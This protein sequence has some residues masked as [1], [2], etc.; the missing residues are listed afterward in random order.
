MRHALR[1]VIAII[2]LIKVLPGAAQETS[3]PTA[4]AIAF[5]DVDI[6]RPAHDRIDRHQTVVLRGQKISAIGPGASL[7]PPPGVR[8]ID[9]RVSYLLA[10]LAE[11][12]AH[13][14]HQ[15]A[16]D[17]YLQDVLFLWAPNGITTIRGM[18]G[19]PSHL[20]LREGRERQ[21]FLG[22]RLLTAGPPFIGKKIK[23]AEGTSR[24]VIG[25]HEAGYGFIKV[26]MGSTVARRMRQPPGPAQTVTCRLPGM[27][28][29]RRICRAPWSSARRQSII[30][31]LTGRRWSATT[32][33]SLISIMDCLVV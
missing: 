27:S 22:P 17:E 19:E 28:R 13:V 8:E 11:M 25:Q 20:E 24:L 23:T 1:I 16:T 6:V 10:G 12:H 21:E 3:E 4:R 15:P 5:V 7:Q 29:Q 14:P 9:A 18:N 31:I 2:C 32:R 33:M 26:H 30:S